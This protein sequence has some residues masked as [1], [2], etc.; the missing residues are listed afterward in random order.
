VTSL[1]RRR[2]KIGVAF[3][4]VGVGLLLTPLPPQVGLSLVVV[5]CVLVAGGGTRA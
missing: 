5:A 1:Q 4:V 2:S 3:V